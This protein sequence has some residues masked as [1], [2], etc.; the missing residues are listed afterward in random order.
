MNIVEEMKCMGDK[1]KHWFNLEEG[2]ERRSTKISRDAQD[3]A[4]TEEEL[5]D[6]AG[7]ESFPASDPPVFRSKSKKDRKR[8]ACK[9]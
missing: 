9:N 8:Y 1:I 2:S 4:F 7:M 3:H 6:Q 5:L